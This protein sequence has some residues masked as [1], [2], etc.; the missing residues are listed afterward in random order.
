MKRERSNGKGGAKKKK[1]LKKTNRNKF[2]E[3]FGSGFLGV[4]GVDS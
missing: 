4:K 1:E 2:K 3:R